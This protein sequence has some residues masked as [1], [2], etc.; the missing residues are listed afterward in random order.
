MNISQ[1]ISFSILAPFYPSE[2]AKK[3]A[4]SA[5][6]GLVF[7]V[8]QLIIFITSPIY[9]NFVSTFNMSINGTIFNVGNKT[10]CSSMLTIRVQTSNIL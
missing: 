9:G 1:T 6:V 2:A 5:E 3:G 10:S 4:S 7:G 8:F